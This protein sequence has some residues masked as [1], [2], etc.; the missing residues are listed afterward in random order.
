[1]SDDR[2]QTLRKGEEVL[3]NLTALRELGVRISLDDFG[4]GYS[5]LDSLRRVPSDALKIDRHPTRSWNLVD[6]TSSR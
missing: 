5:T 1:M 2:S 4:T 3:N 6:R